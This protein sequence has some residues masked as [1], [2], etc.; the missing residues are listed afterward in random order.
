MKN[1]KLLVSALLGASTI[2]V[3]AVVGVAASKKGGFK[4]FA[5]PVE[6]EWHHYAKTNPTSS[7]KGIREYWVQCGGAYQF[8]APS[9]VDIVDKG[10][11]YDVSEFE[12]NDPRYL[13][14][15]YDEN[16]APL[17]AYDYGAGMYC[18]NVSDFKNW[19]ITYG[20][21]G[22]NCNLYSEGGKYLWRIDLPRIDFTKYPTVTMDVLAP[23]W[24]ENN[25]MGPEADQLTY[26]TVYG[27]NKDKGKI[28]LS[29]TG[30]GLHM[31][32]NS[33][34]NQNQ[35]AFENTFTDSDIIN[36]LRSAYFYTEDL[37]DRYLNIANITL[38]TTSNPVDVCSYAGDTSRLSVTNGTV[39][40]AGSVDYGIISKGYAT[41]DTCLVSDGNANPGALVATLPAF[42]FNQH[43][44]LGNVSFKFGVRNNGEHMYFGS[45]DTKVDLGSNSPNSQSENDSG[46]VNWEMIVADGVA[47]V[48]NVYEDTNT[49]VTLT[50]GM[51]NGTESIVLSGGGTSIY[52]R[53]LF[54][55]FYWKLDAD[56]ALVA[57]VSPMDIYSYE[58]D[59]SKLG[60]ENGTAKKPNSA[61]Y[62]IISNGYASE[63]TGMCLE[64]NA[65]PG[66]AV[67]TLPAFNMRPFLEGGKISFKFG[68]KNNNEPMYFGSGDGKVSLGNNSATSQADNNSGYV[69]WEM[70]ITA[71]GASVHNTATG[72]DINVTVTAG[73]RSGTESIVLSGGG[74]S[75][76]RVYLVTDFYWH[77]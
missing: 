41:N 74:T 54:C 13:S 55:D 66:A 6:A 45:G 29:L 71:S 28:E 9:D 12:A 3:G 25:M 68:V 10:T 20:D 72:A 62:S 61:D 34:E 47:Y 53:Y 4:S 59:V 46:Y 77:A 49:I 48:H 58:G 64:G 27:G 15:Q 60:V 42:N 22:Y 5:N 24:Y 36:G 51:R 39:G 14:Y 70:T 31:A 57:P 75:I 21:D 43:T 23:N 65:N 18:T 56:Y 40:L 11:S 73:M 32:F 35:L 16:H 38:S 50:D 17:S 26:H 7:Q 52:R 30:A 69:N 19:R 76:Y 1:K 67:L 44:A 63:F 8:T 2:A 37:Y 33:L